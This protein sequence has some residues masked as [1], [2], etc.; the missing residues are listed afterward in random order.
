MSYLINVNLKYLAEPI[1]T[2]VKNV[3]RY[4]PNKTINKCF[5]R[6]SRATGYFTGLVSVVLDRSK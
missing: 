3:K 4:M 2:Y 6:E 1:K 5:L